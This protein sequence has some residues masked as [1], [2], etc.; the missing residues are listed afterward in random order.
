MEKV[1]E[2][3]DVD[4]FVLENHP[5]KLRITAS[6]NIPGEGWKNPRLEPFAFIQPPPDGIYDF[7]FVADPP[8][9]P[10]TH[11]ITPIGVVHL[12]DPLPPGAK[13]VRIHVKRDSK[14]ALLDNSE[15]SERNPGLG[16]SERPE[17][18]PK[19][20]NSQHPKRNPSRFTFVDQESVKRVVFF[21]QA[22]G[23][24]GAKEKPQ[25]ASLEYTGPEGHFVFRGSQI[26]Q[27]QTVAGTLVSV[28]FRSGAAD[29]PSM[30]FALILPPVELGEELRQNF[31]TM[32][33]LIHSRGFV[34]DHPGAQLTYEAVNLEGIAEYIPVL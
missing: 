16:N 29:E 15:H 14:K 10:A 8:Q 33:I 30:D 17:R 12:W 6:G 2:V 31:K 28:N 13:G 26:T 4:L 27:Q 24:L 32:G 19:L 9:E 3:L 18:N 5:P 22:S 21:P 25:E 20:S 7:D 34:V 1:L 23:P 11:A